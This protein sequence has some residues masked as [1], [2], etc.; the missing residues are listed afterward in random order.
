[1]DSATGSLSLG[2]DD[3]GESGCRM[4]VA[5]KVTVDW[6]VAGALKMGCWPVAATTVV[7]LV[8]PRLALGR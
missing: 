5:I 7:A 8:P 1:M 3:G 2:G 4:V 6:K